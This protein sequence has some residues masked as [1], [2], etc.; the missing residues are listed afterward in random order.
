MAYAVPSPVEIRINDRVKIKVKGD[1]QQCPSHT[2]KVP[3][4][5]FARPGQ[6]RT[7]GLYHWSSR[8]KGRQNQAWRFPNNHGYLWARVRIF[9]SPRIF[10]NLNYTIAKAKAAKKAQS[11][12]PKRY[13]FAGK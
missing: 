12:S 2:V 11:S 9:D 10:A 13:N 7:S 1:G 8:T 6:T 5:E 3:A 4:P